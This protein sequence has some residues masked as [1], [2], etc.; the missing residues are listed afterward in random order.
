MSEQKIID[1]YAARRMTTREI[2]KAS[3]RSYA[4]VRKVLTG[5][6][7]HFTKKI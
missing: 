7:Y 2:A 1:T 4:N 6:G 5:A 3:D